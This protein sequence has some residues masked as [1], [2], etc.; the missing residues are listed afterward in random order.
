MRRI[1]PNP[2]QNP[3]LSQS[4]DHVL[5]LVESFP[6]NRLTTTCPVARENPDRH[7][8]E[9][10]PLSTAN[11]EQIKVVLPDDLA[12]THIVKYM[13]KTRYTYTYTYMQYISIYNI[14]CT[15]YS[16][17]DTRYNIQILQITYHILHIAYYILHSTYVYYIHNIYNIYNIYYITIYYKLYTYT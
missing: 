10:F 2:W 6:S 16:K 12:S 17:E 5:H 15:I 13:S 1:N 4:L 14:Q 7:Q 8:P 3:S 11:K 9:H